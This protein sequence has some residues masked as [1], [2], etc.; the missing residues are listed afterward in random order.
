[1]H[2]FFCLFLL[3]IHS[4]SPL[5][6]CHNE[7]CHRLHAPHIYTYKVWGS[8]Q[9]NIAWP[10]FV[11]TFLP[12]YHNRENLSWCPPLSGIRLVPPLSRGL[13]FELNPQIE[14]THMC[15]SDCLFFLCL[16]DSYLASSCWLSTM[17]I[18]GS[19]GPIT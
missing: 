7:E 19:W 6:D 12:Q 14:H 18:K 15:V 4:Q 16:C 8:T 17:M 2:T 10:L 9:C 3:P 11:V 5:K 13:G 1:L